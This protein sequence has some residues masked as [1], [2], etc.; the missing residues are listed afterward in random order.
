MLILN[1]TNFLATY[2]SLYI[3]LLTSSILHNI[4]F[5]LETPTFI[6]T[7]NFF[8]IYNMLTV[9]DKL[10]NVGIEISIDLCVEKGMK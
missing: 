6:F 8:L 1:S 2:I 7:Y 9:G 3:P 4:Y 5:S 10:G